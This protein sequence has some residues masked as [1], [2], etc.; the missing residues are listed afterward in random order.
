[1]WSPLTVNGAMP[2]PLGSDG[3]TSGALPLTS[4]PSL[5][6]RGWLSSPMR[7][8]P[9]VTSSTGME[10]PSKRRAWSASGEAFADVGHADDADADVVGGTTEEDRGSL[11]HL[12]PYSSQER[13]R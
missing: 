7:R 11:L 1:M 3:D 8:R 5:T 12:G 13:L 10:S 2:I 4:E 9:G 6:I